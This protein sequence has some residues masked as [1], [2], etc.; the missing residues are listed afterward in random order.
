MFRNACVHGYH[1]PQHKDFSVRVPLN[2]K[3]GNH[4]ALARSHIPYLHQDPWN[5]RPAFPYCWELFQNPSRP[6]RAIPLTDLRERA[7]VMEG[8]NIRRTRLVR[9]CVLEHGGRKNYSQ[10]SLD[11]RMLIARGASIRIQI[12]AVTED[13]VRLSY[14]VVWAQ[15]LARPAS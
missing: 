2:R 10:P 1:R 8:P 14:Q 13:R 7:K 9:S 3:N 11:F 15:I 5:V 12:P 6:R 4:C